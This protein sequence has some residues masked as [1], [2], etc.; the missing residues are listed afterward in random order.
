MSVTK[1]KEIENSTDTADALSK[2]IISSIVQYIESSEFQ[3]THE[4]RK[5]DLLNASNLC[6]GCLIA[7]SANNDTQES[8]L[9]YNI[10]STV[11]ENIITA[12]KDKEGAISLDSSLQLLKALI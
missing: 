8:F 9:L 4:G 10:F 5:E 7:L 6:L 12:T 1:Y 3:P 11:N 2:R